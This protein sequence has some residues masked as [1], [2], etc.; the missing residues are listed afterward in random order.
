MGRKATA[1]IGYVG[2]AALVMGCR[3][4]S[5][6]VPVPDP[7]RPHS[8]DAG[9]GDVMKPEAGLVVDAGPGEVGLDAS[10]EDTGLDAALGPDAEVQDVAIPDAEP[11]VPCSPN[12]IDHVLKFGIDGVTFM[13]LSADGRLMGFSTRDRLS[14]LDLNS[15][16]DAYVID[17]LSGRVDL[18]S[19]A[20]NGGVPGQSRM[21]N[22]VGNGRYIVIGSSQPLVPGGIVNNAYLRDRVAGT[23]T[24]LSEFP[25]LLRTPYGRFQT[26]STGGLL[27]FNILISR[28]PNPNTGVFVYRRGQPEVEPISVDNQGQLAD[29][30]NHLIDMT[31]DGRYVVFSS[32]STVLSRISPSSDG[33]QI[34]LRDRLMGSTEL[35]CTSSTGAACNRPTAGVGSMSD[36]GRYVAFISSATNLVSGQP[37]NG[38]S[39]LFMKDRWTGTV[40]AEPA[41]PAPVGLASVSDFALSPDGQHIVVSAGSGDVSGQDPSPCFWGARGFYVRNL[42]TQRGMRLSCPTAGPS[43]LFS[44]PTNGYLEWSGD[45]RFIGFYSDAEV[46]PGTL[47]DRWDAFV[48]HYCPSDRD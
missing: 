32:D 40:I 5:L 37:A 39:A 34:F 36:D 23:T 18:A 2:F 20:A 14:P 29:G 7:P 46:T 19:I 24:W 6:D 41:A 45:G 13:P 38:L 47:D 9:A 17:R 10:F 30:L 1:I 21:L 15:D 33:R 16:Y 22:M 12:Q 43:S 42:T 4:T 8:Q 31:P 35:V 48:F 25:R 27:L 26:D 44:V 3:Q 11:N 28:A